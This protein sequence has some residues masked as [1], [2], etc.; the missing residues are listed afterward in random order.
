MNFKRRKLLVL[1]PLMILLLAPLQQSFAQQVT[2]AQDPKLEGAVRLAYDLSRDNFAA[3]S[4][5]GGLGIRLMPPPE[6]M[7]KMMQ[8]AQ[9]PPDQVPKDPYLLMAVY[10]SGDPTLP[11]DAKVSFADMS[12]GRWNPSKMDKSITPAAQAMLGLKL[13]EWSKFFHLTYAGGPPI[14]YTPEMERFLTLVLITESKMITQFSANMLLTDNGFVHKIES[15]GKDRKVTDPTIQPI[16]QVTMLWL[17]SDLAQVTN[18]DTFFTLKDPETSKAMKDL[19]DKTFNFVKAN[20]ATKIEDKGISVVALLWYATTTENGKLREEAISLIKEYADSLGSD[21]KT[22]PEI[23][24]SIRGLGEAWRITGDVKYLKNA[25]DLWNKLDELWDAQANFYTKSK[26]ASEYKY[27]TFEVGMIFGGLNEARNIVGKESADFRI[28]R[29]AEQRFV[30]AMTTFV[31]NGLKIPAKTFPPL[32]FAAETTYDK[33]TKKWTVTRPIYETAGV[34][35]LANELIWAEGTQVNPYPSVSKALIGRALYLATA[36]D[37]KAAISQ[38]QSKQIQTLSEQVASLKSE[39]D[40]AKSQLEKARTENQ[41]SNN[42]VETL[43]RDL[44]GTQ[45]LTS[46]AGIVSIIIG[47]AVGFAVGRRK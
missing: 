41:A 18:D 38:D 29:T 36:T 13:I 2:R 30:D 12:Q 19:A 21:V 43:R 10:A 45:S 24:A 39:V 32:L 40:S 42:Q 20:K 3:A 26:G 46:L 7:Q 23:A 22:A 14:F 27:S 1:L 5:V 11:A 33:G 31:V 8:M 25:I 6:D 4:M 28:T 17:I 35:Y 34:Q 44:S 15:D 47:L 9:L 37:G 16:D